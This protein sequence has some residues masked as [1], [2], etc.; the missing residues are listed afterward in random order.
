MPPPKKRVKIAR[1]RRRIGNRFMKEI[2]FRPDKCRYALEIQPPYGTL[3]LTGQKPIET[4]RYALPD[5]L[6]AR[7]ILLIEQTTQGVEG[8]SSLSDRIEHNQSDVK[9][10]GTVHFSESFRYATKEQW[11]NDQALHCVPAGSQFDWTD[12]CELWG[13]RVSEVSRYEGPQEVRGMTR[14]LRSLFEIDSS[15]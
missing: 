6:L 7:E 14:V 2:K 8:V 5:E 10:V 1:S 9:A 11:D 15:E 4:R 12:G 3:I 13:W